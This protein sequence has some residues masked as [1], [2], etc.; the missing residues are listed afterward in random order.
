MHSSFP[1]QKTRS[2]LQNFRRLWRVSISGR[3]LVNYAIFQVR[4][5]FVVPRGGIRVAPSPNSRKNL[6]FVS[7]CNAKRNFLPGFFGSLL[8]ASL[9]SWDWILYRYYGNAIQYTTYTARC[10]IR[11]MFVCEPRSP[12]GWLWG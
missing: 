12:S 6:R 11:N 1:V 5:D 10:Y 7:K 8:Y 4:G 9:L 3:A 2:E